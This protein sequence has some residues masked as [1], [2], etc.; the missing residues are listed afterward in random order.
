MVRLPLDLSSTGTDVL[1]EQID[2]ALF[3][4]HPLAD[5]RTTSASG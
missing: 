3:V 2:R 1:G 5:V 4:G